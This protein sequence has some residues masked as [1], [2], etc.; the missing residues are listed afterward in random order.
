MP[1]RETLF[2]QNLNQTQIF[3]R[4]HDFSFVHLRL[5]SRNFAGKACD[6]RFTPVSIRWEV[7]SAFLLYLF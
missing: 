7:G 1:M 2:Y 3:C 5:V 4:T 6:P